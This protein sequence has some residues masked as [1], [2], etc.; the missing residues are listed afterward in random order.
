MSTPRSF[1]V[2]DT[3]RLAHKFHIETMSKKGHS[4]KV[5]SCPITAVEWLSTHWCDVVIMEIIFETIDGLSLVRQ[6]RS[7][8]PEL[9]IVIFTTKPFSPVMVAKDTADA[10]VTKGGC[11]L[12]PFEIALKFLRERVTA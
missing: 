8:F 9:V 11:G 7:R 5:E 1:L 3:R 12:K 4:V 10:L 2:I 6:I